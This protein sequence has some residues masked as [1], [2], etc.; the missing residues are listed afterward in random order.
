MLPGRRVFEIRRKVEC[1]CY[2]QVYKGGSACPCCQ[3]KT[4]P[5][6]KK[7]RVGRSRGTAILV[8]GGGSVRESANDAPKRLAYLGLGE[9]GGRGELRKREG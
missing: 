7:P 9:W 3:P 6:K 8:E 2:I 5:P 1:G 4:P